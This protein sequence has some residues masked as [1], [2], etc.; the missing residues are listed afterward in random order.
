MPSGDFPVHFDVPTALS[1]APGL[2]KAAITSI[3]IALLS[4]LVATIFGL[5]V[6]LLRRI[7]TI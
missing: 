3:W 4:A 1:L 2:L 6:E 5:C 7:G